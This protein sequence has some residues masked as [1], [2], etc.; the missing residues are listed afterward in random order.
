M[1]LLRYFKFVLIW[2]FL[3]LTKLSCYS[4]K[5][6][7][8][9]YVLNPFML[10]TH[11]CLRAF[12]YL[13]TSNG[14]KNLLYSHICELERR[15][16]ITLFTCLNLIASILHHNIM[17][18]SVLP[19]LTV[20]TV[21]HKSNLTKILNYLK[22]ARLTVNLISMYLQSW[23]FYPTLGLLLLFVNYLIAFGSVILYPLRINVKCSDLL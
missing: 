10:I 7:T 4:V 14:T 11:K 13:F 16:L 19:L 8:S 12:G 5:P 6:A 23:I 18:L 9:E 3:K 2:I 22:C 20:I 15:L 17:S 21:C 1:L